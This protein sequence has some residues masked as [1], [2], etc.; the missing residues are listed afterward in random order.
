MIKDQ[1][2]KERKI[3]ELCDYFGEE[4]LKKIKK[5]I[6][7]KP[8]DLNK[9]RKNINLYNISSYL[10]ETNI[11]LKGVKRIEKLL[12][13]KREIY[14]ARKV[15]Q[16]VINEDII[17]NNYFDYDHTYNAKLQRLAE[18]KLYN[19]FVGESSLSKNSMKISKKKKTENQKLFKTLKG[20][21]DNFLDKKSL[22]YLI[23]KHRAIN[24]RQ[25]K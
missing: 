11:V 20:G 8:I 4:E 7:I 10:N 17:A 24:N 14:L 16:N 5:K 23:F 21:L 2:S 1:I 25:N 15:A 6:K 18:R 12:T 3:E 19:R 22:E 13:N 9:V